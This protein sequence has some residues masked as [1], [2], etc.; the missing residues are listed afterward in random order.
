M[1]PIGVATQGRRS[2]GEEGSEALGPGAG[3]F[4]WDGTTQVSGHW[5][6]I[7]ASGRGQG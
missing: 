6:G 4:K 7:A 2:R 3:L 5:G 1:W